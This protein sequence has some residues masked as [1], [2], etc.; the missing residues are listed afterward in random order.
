MKKTWLVLLSALGLV[1]FLSVH[2][3]RGVKNDSGGP[4]ATSQPVSQPGQ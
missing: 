3:C 4:N 2:A 1:A